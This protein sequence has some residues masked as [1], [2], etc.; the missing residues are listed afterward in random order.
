MTVGNRL[1]T[2]PDQQELYLGDT[3]CCWPTPPMASDWQVA[4]QGLVLG[5]NSE[6]CI[7]AISGLGLPGTRADDVPN[8][9][10]HGT[11]ALG[12][13]S[14]GRAITVEV[15]G[16]FADSAIAWDK[17]RQL[18]GVWQPN[19]WDQPLRIRA[20]GDRSLIAIGHP[21]RLAEN[22][23]G[24]YRGIVRATLEFYADDPRLYETAVTRE[25]INID[26]A[27]DE[28]GYCFDTGL[29]G[30]SFCIPDTTGICIPRGI[31]GSR[32]I[33]NEGNTRTA[34][35]IVVVGNA[36]NIRAENARTGQWWEWE[37][38]TGSGEFWM[39][40]LF[41]TCT[42]DDAAV[43]QNLKV[44]STFWWLDPGDSLVNIR[45]DSGSAYSE[46]RFRSAWF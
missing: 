37:G 3:Y 8:T 9:F 18:A 5:K 31:S 43:Y 30:G 33:T 42:L 46:V 26:P 15:T 45:V 13:F 22:T 39:D 14:E 17:L 19:V 34:P 10:L 44:G 36:T 16:K 41:R 6:W 28:A 32:V 7:T 38:T 25:L 27:N 11:S 40:H 20:T 23:S 1:T 29:P 12:D 4:L 2:P 24:L 21:R 35:I